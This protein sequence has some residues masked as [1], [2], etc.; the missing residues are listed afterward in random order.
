MTVDVFDINT[1]R[2]ATA[3]SW[4]SAV[5]TGASR[6]KATSLTTAHKLAGK[7][8][9]RPRKESS[10]PAHLKPRS[11]HCAKAQSTAS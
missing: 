8:K 4:C 6:T 2:L 3:L 5:D 7:T 1:C 9:V 10:K 11:R